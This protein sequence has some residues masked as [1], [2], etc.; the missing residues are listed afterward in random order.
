[1]SSNIHP[2][3]VI[4]DS[5]V[6]GANNEI[7]P[8]CVIGP[9]VIIGD[10]N[11]LRSHVVVEKYTTIGSGNDFFQFSSIGADPQDYTYKGEPTRLE[12]GSNNVFRECCTINRGT[13][14][15]DGLTKLGNNSLYM[16]Y[17]HI[18]HDC[19]IGDYCT[20]ANSCNVAGHVK[21][22]DNVIIGGAT[23][24][25]QFVKLGHGS[26][27]GGASAI[28]KDVPSFCTAYGNRVTL[29]GINIIGMRRKDIDRKSIS[30]VVDFFRTMES[31]GLAP[32]SFI[33]NDELMKDFAK[34]PIIQIMCEEMNNSQVGVAPFAS[35]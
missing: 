25:S 26:Y 5:A 10:N 18:G 23:S 28:N 19:V 29:R 7:G 3:A 17:V 32:A 31:S 27:V 4:D 16:A 8:F 6:I 21:I 14:K 30:L 9:H 20:I 12:I 34:D 22:Q 33:S 11:K 35:V 1:M 24:V 2:T 13:L 15:E